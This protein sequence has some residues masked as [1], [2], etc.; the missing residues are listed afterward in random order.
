MDQSEI[1]QLVLE[2]KAAIADLEALLRDPVLPQ[3]GGL[4]D[5]IEV[6]AAVFKIPTDTPILIADAKFNAVEFFDDFRRH[7]R[8]HGVAK[9][10][11][12][13]V[14]LV[15]IQDRTLANNYETWLDSPETVRAFSRAAAPW[16]LVV[17]FWKTM[18]PQA[19]NGDDYFDD[20]REFC[21]GSQGNRDINSHNG[22]FDLKVRKA[23]V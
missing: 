4:G 17:D 7:M 20:F 23:D 11:W 19:D 12:C 16:D 2:Q 13:R 10:H 8:G 5:G 21:R 18:F 14:L 3:V 6:K 15:K 9:E 22:L 1:H